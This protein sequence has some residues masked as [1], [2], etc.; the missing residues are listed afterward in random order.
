MSEHQQDESP[1]IGALAAALSKAQGA[2]KNATKDS[3]NPHFKS[4]YA[5]LES[6]W[7]ACRAPLSANELAVV[8]RVSTGTGGIVLTT[9]LIHSSGEW[10]RDK[11]QMPSREQ[12]AQ[13]YGSAIT[14]ARRYAL[15]A[16]VG[17]APGEDD[18]GN[19]ATIT[20]PGV[21]RQ[22]AVGG[23]SA[24]DNL[25]AKLL[26]QVNT[27]SAQTP[28]ERIRAIG[29]E[30]GKTGKALSSFVKGCCGNKTAESLTN[31]DVE[32]VSA[33]FKALHP[34]GVTSDGEPPDDVALP[35]AA[36]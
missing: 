7:A 20:E 14:Y 10:I 8:Q 24:T 28:L 31:A 2:M 4:K 35:Q 6:I 27:P 25:R 23:Q 26:A 3:T 33:A 22:S 21:Q 5:D 30:F 15:A 32:R 12:S 16:M 13:G 36:Q 17:V 29:A 18:D 11:C 9:M 19:Q 1:S 34:A